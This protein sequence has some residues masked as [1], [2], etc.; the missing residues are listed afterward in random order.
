MGKLRIE[1]GNW[2]RFFSGTFYS[3]DFTMN[4]VNTGLHPMPTIDVVTVVEPTGLEITSEQGTAIAPNNSVTLQGQESELDTANT[5]WLILV[6][7]W[8]NR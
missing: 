2:D 3:T 5:R 4:P 8:N 6:S 7:I 1:N